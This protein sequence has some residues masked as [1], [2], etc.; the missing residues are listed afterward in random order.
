LIKPEEIADMIGYCL[1][2]K[3]LNAT[4]IEITGGLCYPNNI[5]K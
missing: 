2:N 5:A 4:T 1:A 3:A